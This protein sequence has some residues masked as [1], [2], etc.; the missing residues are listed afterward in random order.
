MRAAQGGCVQSFNRIYEKHAGLLYSIAYA[1]LKDEAEAGSVIQDVFNRVWQGKIRRPDG[2]RSVAAWLS[3]ITRNAAIDQF[4]KS[5]RRGARE[6]TTYDEHWIERRSK[7]AT[8][9]APTESLLARERAQEVREA[10]ESIE[11][12]KRRLVWMSF[13]SGKTHQEIADELGVPL[14][15]VKTNIRRTLRALR[16]R[17]KRS[18][19]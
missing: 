19:E 15:T 3:A 2:L 7:A 16:E 10:L 18:K 6:A 1:I 13:Y 9:P 11:P 4:R 14:G 5:K 12:G 8:G 17:L